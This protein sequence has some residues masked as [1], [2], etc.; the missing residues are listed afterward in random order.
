[1]TLS[2][3]AVYRTGERLD[4]VPKLGAEIINLKR[5]AESDTKEW[6]CYNPSIGYSPKQGYAVAFRSA[7]YVILK[8][9]GELHVTN[10][11]K[12]RNRIYFAEFDEGFNLQ[13]FRRIEVPKQVCDTPRG[14]ED[15]RL[16]WRGNSWYFTGTMMEEHTP[17]ARV[18]VC[19]LDAKAEYVTEVKILDGVR[20]SKPE[21]SWLVPDLKTNKTF[22]FIYGPHAIVKGDKIINTMTDHQLSD[23]LR[24]N[25][26]IVEQKDGSYITIMH[27]LWTKKVYG[28]SP[29]TFGEVE[30]LDK[31]YSHYFVRFNRHGE[32]TEMS[33][34]FKFISAGIE[35]AAGMVEKDNNFVVSFGKDDVSSH[36]AI[37]PKHRVLE[38]MY[39]VK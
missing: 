17:V 38:I 20:P 25:A 36:L 24:G 23:G 12:I 31:T 14:I 13:N 37:I 11:G 26:H 3:N 33:I 28:K 30:G 21:K 6:S 29:N 22:D 8:P 16:F 1:M 34:G 19:K 18:C 15:P 10:G 9:H 5:F 39:P 35:F 27:K 7:N 4:K 32:L 2:G